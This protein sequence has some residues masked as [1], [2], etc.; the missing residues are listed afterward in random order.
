MVYRMELPYDELVDILD[1]KYFAGSS[2]GYTLPPEKNEI[3]DLNSMIKSFL[4]M[5]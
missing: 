4:P 5:T 3:S 1:L 2:V